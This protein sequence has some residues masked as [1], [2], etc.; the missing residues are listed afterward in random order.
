MKLNAK[1]LFHQVHAYLKQ[2]KN[3][4]SN[5]N[6]FHHGVHKKKKIVKQ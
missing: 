1:R 2:T 3:K 4:C 6:S 5:T